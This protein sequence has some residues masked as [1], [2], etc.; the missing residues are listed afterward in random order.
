LRYIVVAQ[1]EHFEREVAGLDQQRTFTTWDFDARLLQ[2]VHGVFV[3][4]AFR[5]NC[6]S[7]H[8]CFVL[9]FLVYN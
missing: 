7:Y 3:E 8:V 6:N 1:I 4:A 2:Q 5:L 9:M